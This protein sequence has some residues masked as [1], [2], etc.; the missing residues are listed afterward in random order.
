MYR[1]LANALP[2]VR[3]RKQKTPDEATSSSV[4]KLQGPEQDRYFSLRTSSRI[5][6]VFS[7]SCSA[8]VAWA[9]GALGVGTA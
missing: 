1:V 3:C 6:A 2:S 4:L 7:E 9:E 5:L 8:E